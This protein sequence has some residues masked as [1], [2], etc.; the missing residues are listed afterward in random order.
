MSSN[1]NPDT[2]TPSYTMGY[3]DE[4]AKLLDRR[5][6]GI[7]ATHLLPYLKPGLRVLDLGCGPG[8]ISVGLAKVVE[9]GEL[10]GIDMEESQI[11]IARAAATAGGHDNAV[12]RTGDVTRLSYEDDTFDVAHCHALLMHV[13]D[14]QAVLAEVKRVLKSGGLVSAREMIGSASFSE[15]ELDGLAD[16]WVT[17]SKLLEA[18]GGHPQMGKELPRKFLQAGFSAIHASASFDYY[19]TVEDVAFYHTFAVGW[20]FSSQTVE[21]TIKHGLATREQFETWRRLLEQWKNSPGAVAAIAWG[22]AI[23]QKP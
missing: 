19:G 22:E 3:S 5:N 10:Q 15:P 2:P 6:S 8:T 1:R 20:F 21:A 14:T 9:P 13:R 16:A 23:G 7:N 18:N 12:F 11:K 4:F 17:F